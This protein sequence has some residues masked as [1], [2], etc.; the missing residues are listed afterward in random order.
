MVETPDQVIPTIFKKAH[1]AITIQFVHENE[2][3]VS[4]LKMFLKRSLTNDIGITPKHGSKCALASVAFS[5]ASDV[6]L[7]HLSSKKNKRSKTIDGRKLLEKY[8]LCNSRYR[9]FAFQM[10]QLAIGLYLDADVRITKGI[11]LL[12]SSTITR[13]SLEALMHA[14]GGEMTLNKAAVVKVFQ[15]KGSGSPENV[16]LQAWAAFHVAGLESMIQKVRG[17]RAIDTL[18]MNEEVRTISSPQSISC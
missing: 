10:D 5:T 17:V 1:P 6:L 12:S 7:V 3:T 16:A 11:D 18:T 8:I 13:Q 4:M 2:L 9:K 14:L 15:D